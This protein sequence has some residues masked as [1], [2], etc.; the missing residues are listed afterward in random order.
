MLAEEGRREAKENKRQQRYEA[1]L[2]AT[3]KA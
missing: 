1:K 3:C 2:A